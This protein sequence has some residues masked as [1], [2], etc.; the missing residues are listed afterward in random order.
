MAAVARLSTPRFSEHTLHMLSG[1]AGTEA[2]DASDLADG[3]ALHQPAANLQFAAGK[4]NGR[5]S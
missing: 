2:E 3:L 1:G 4:C 5:L